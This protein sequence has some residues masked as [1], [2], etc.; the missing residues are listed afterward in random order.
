M[1]LLFF[2][3]CFLTTCLQFLYLI[4]EVQLRT[5][6]SP[7]PRGIFRAPV[8]F[9]FFRQGKAPPHSFL[10]ASPITEQTPLLRVGVKSFGKDHTY[11]LNYIYLFLCGNWGYCLCHSEYVEVRGQG[12]LLLLCRF[13]GSNSGYLAWWQ[14]LYQTNHFAVLDWWFVVCFLHASAYTSRQFSYV[15]CCSLKRGKGK[16]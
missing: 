9:T 8:L 6:A 11:F 1:V 5:A 15:N 13:Q 10:Q 3:F 4:S 12:S 7:S 16:I 2:F 14:V